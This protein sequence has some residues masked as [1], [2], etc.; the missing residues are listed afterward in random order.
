MLPQEEGG[1]TQGG[2]LTQEEEGLTQGSMLPQEE[3][4]LPQSKTKSLNEP[5][6]IGSSKILSAFEP[7]REREG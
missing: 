6:K 3:L 7:K 1:L 4:D 5:Q 2:I